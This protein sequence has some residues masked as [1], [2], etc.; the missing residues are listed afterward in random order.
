MK[1]LI[2]GGHLSPA[3]AVIETYLKKGLP[4]EIIFVGRKYIN[5]FEKTLSL[6]YREVTKRNIRFIPLRAGRFTRI[7]SLRSFLNLLY[8][9][10]GFFE[11]WQIIRKEKPDVILSFGSYL[12][13]PIA[14]ISFFYKIP[15]FTHEQTISPGLANRIIGFLA[16]RVFLA[17]PEAEKFF[18]KNKVEI[19]GNP[20][21]EVI[22][23][24]KKRIP[25]IKKD[26]PVIY[27]TGGSLGSHA[28]NNHIKNIIY[29]ML[30]KYIVIHQTGDV[31]QYHDYEE[32]LKIREKL[33]P[34]LKSRYFLKKHFFEEEIGYIYSIA[35]IVVARAGA[36]TFFELLALAK[37][38][39]FIPLPWSANNEQ[40]FQAKIF[41]KA[42]A[43]VIFNQKD[44]SQLLLQLIDKIIKAKDEYK[45]N[46]IRLKHLFKKNAAEHIIKRISTGL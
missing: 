32:F 40:Y 8:I 14:V 9:P 4:G 25:S 10:V 24:V 19:V 38:T 7:L 35:D 44:S 17:F 26:R 41:E 5:E 42:K 11:A 15:I 43:G 23:T 3:L 28:I 18:D 16:K 1:I 39:I 13:L 45:K 22:F 37:P 20:V 2:T 21:R 30:K 33:P 46:F 27:I 34:M 31:K 12:A 36:N 29:P 6:E